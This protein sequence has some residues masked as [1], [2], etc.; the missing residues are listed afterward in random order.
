MHT[1][2][3]RLLAYYTEIVECGSIRSASRKLNISPAV[4]SKALSDLEEYLGMTLLKRG[5][6]KVEITPDGQ[7]IYNHALTMVDA[8]ATAVDLGKKENEDISGE[9]NITLPSD[10]CICWLPEIL[11]G[12][13]AKYPKIKTFF[14]A[15]DQTIDLGTS[16]FDIAV[17]SKHNMKESQAA[18]V[19]LN[20]PVTL[21]CHPDLI[22]N[23]KADLAEILA[24]VPYI[25]FSH[26]IVETQVKGLNKRTQ[27]IET[28]SVSPE[29]SV[30]VGY[31]TKEL[32]RA[33][34]GIALIVEATIKQDEL[35]GDLIKVSQDHDFGYLAI[36][37]VT[38][39]RLHSPTVR[40][41]LKYAKDQYGK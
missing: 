22:P 19:F 18:D 9:L 8:A 16:N 6:R 13:K 25:G 26:G 28:F 41:F 37:L 29:F 31:L 27:R 2:H 23:S 35:N 15:Q 33:K 20:L 12:F 40:A 4:L 32:A 21:T 3:F 39:D 7:E 1:H 38:R 34:F 11:D 17:R 10:L 30:N 24:N 5:K 36:R 14:A